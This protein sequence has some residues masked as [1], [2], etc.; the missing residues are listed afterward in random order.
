MTN[1]IPPIYHHRNNKT[2]KENEPMNTTQVTS[3][4]NIRWITSLSLIL[5]L[6]LSLGINY[7]TYTQ[8]QHVLI[9]KEN[10]Q[11]D[12]P[13]HIKIFENIYDKIGKL[14][15]VLTLGSVLT[16]LSL[17]GFILWFLLAASKTTSTLSH[18]AEVLGSSAE[19]VSTTSGE[20][21]SSSQALAEGSSEQAASVEE[22]SAS[23]EEMASMAKSNSNS[24]NNAKS[25]ADQA[26]KAAES[27]ASSIIELDEAMSAI[28][29]SSDNIS[30]I[31]KTID[32]I[33]FQTNI[34]AL[35]AAVEAA[36][37][38]EAGAGF[39]VVADEVRNLAQRSA[40]AARE[41]AEQIEES[42]ESGQNG[43][44]IATKVKNSLDIIVEKVRLV[45]T[46]I[47]EIA[48]ASQEQSTGVEELMKA[49]S[50]IDR[51]TQHNAASSEQ[52]AAAA[53][54]LSS[55]SLSL[56]QSIYELTKVIHGR[57]SDQS[58]SFSQKMDV[59]TANIQPEPQAQ[60]AKPSLSHR[61]SKSQKSETPKLALGNKSPSGGKD[62]FDEFFK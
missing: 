3:M 7:Y 41:T 53:E 62:E 45:D 16:G 25:V 51:V 55:Q 59:R 57:R 18:V 54:E 58:Q 36:R 42:I 10:I 28:Q 38:G 19:I 4:Q 32:E 49:V 31:I 6:L 48:A 11:L 56:K 12:Q 13:E 9:E 47:A 23:L 8:L 20:L 26:R 2:F 46:I 43:V 15:K 35:N 22:T 40:V 34:L 52:T 17:L 29:S 30:K 5:I 37:A 21:A 14:E 27:G 50:E 61:T 39:A 24:A 33:A 1:P 44:N 60:F